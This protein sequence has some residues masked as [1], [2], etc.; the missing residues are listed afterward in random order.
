M[1]WMPKQSKIK[2]S[3]ADLNFLRLDSGLFKEISQRLEKTDISIENLDGEVPVGSNPMKVLGLSVSQ[4]NFKEQTELLE[5]LLE[6]DET[7]SVLILDEGLETQEIIAL[8]E[9]PRV[10]AVVEFPSLSEEL[11]KKAVEHHI[12]LKSQS[13]QRQELKEQ[14]KKLETLNENLEN[15]VHERTKKEFQA[16]QATE[17]SLKKIQSIFSF[18]KNVSKC[19]SIEEL[20]IQLREE[21]KKI[22]GLMPPILI[23]DEGVISFRVFYFQGKQLIE[24]YSDMAPDHSGFYGEDEK[25]MKSALSNYFGR[26]F[27]PLMTQ[28]LNFRSNELRGVK[29]RV[30]FEHSL[31]NQDSADILDGHDE[32]WT[33]LTMAVENL[34]LKEGMQNIAKQWSKTFNKMEDP[35]LILDENFQ[36]SLSNSN[37]HR[38]ENRTCYEAFA[39]QEKPCKDCP[40]SKTFQTG[41]PQT[42]DVHMGN[43]VY[44]V[45]SYPIRMEEEGRVTHAINQYV[46]VT[47]TIDLRSRVIQGEKM[48]AVGLLAG[49]IAHELNNPL[50]GIYSLADLLLEDFDQEGN[51]YK[52]ML[53]IKDA[54]RRCQ[55]IIK[56]LL[57]FSSVE[58]QSKPVDI[59]VNAIISKTLPLL[60]MAMR[61]MNS[62]VNLHEEPLNVNC[63]PQLLQQVIF[64]LINNACQAMEPGGELGVFTEKGGEQVFIYIRDTGPGIPDDIREFIFDPFFTTKDEGKGTGLGLSMS[65]SVVQRAGGELSLNDAY[66]GGTEFIIQLPLVD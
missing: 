54:A 18:I 23:L 41:K 7:L 59:D 64:N 22:S 24:K 20:L 62:N 25:E 35:I 43:K 60:K 39:D 61:E 4:K 58:N 34:L 49:N 38:R 51:T 57:D 30:I 56:D 26:P 55:R 1:R 11:I 63:N 16:S 27:G 65:R 42:S 5:T 32:R 31:E 17:A 53:E 15:L 21:F 46:D 48:A 37:Y 12:F 29:A 40:L 47:Q 36:M 8:G 28:D 50:T 44:R 10:F 14:N 52:D 66:P 45:H 9:S 2:E 13:L 3:G 6:N 19:Q 33:I